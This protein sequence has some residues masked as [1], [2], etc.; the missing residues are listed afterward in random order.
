MRGMEARV[1]FAS[2]RVVFALD[3]RLNF[4]AFMCLGSVLG[5]QLIA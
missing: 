3:T 4:D 5:R 1:V 2:D